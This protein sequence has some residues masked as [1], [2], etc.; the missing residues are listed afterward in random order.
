ME[1]RRNLQGCGIC[2]ASII[3]RS[4]IQTLLQGAQAGQFDIMLTETLDR[5]SRDQADV[6]TLFKRL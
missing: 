3:L 5:I 2:G 1:G 4:G 6:A